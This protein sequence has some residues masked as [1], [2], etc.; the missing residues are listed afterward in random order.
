MFVYIKKF[1]FLAIPRIFRLVTLNTYFLFDLHDS[2][3]V[4]MNIF[5]FCAVYK[6]GRKWEIS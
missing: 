1:F 6:V 3:S 4:G 2:G 5:A